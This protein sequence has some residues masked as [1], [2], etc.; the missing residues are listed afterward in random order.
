M[1]PMRRVLPMSLVL[2]LGL[3]AGLLGCRASDD[4]CSELARHVIDLAVAEGE[5]ANSTALVLEQECQRMRPSDGL[6]QC[7]LDAQSLSAL[8]EC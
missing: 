5:A 2:S 1:A 3:A 7:M 4:Q 6:V 8:S